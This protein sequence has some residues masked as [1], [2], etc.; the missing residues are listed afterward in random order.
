M[1]IRFKTCFTRLS[2]E[3]IISV[4]SCSLTHFVT[5]IICQT[6]R[7]RNYYK[8]GIMVCYTTI[9]LFRGERSAT[10]TPSTY[11]IL[12]DLERIK[13]MTIV[14]RTSKKIK[15]MDFN[16]KVL[17]YIFVRKI[18]FGTLFDVKNKKKEKN[19]DLSNRD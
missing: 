12:R 6:N 13:T 4:L 19:K 18:F 10:A 1:Y 5:L 16:I 2:R 15:K 7:S 9:N 3:N 11:I 17:S 8:R 14:L